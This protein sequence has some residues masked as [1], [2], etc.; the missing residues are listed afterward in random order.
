MKYTTDIK[1]PEFDE[2]GFATSNG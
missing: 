1:T 2:N